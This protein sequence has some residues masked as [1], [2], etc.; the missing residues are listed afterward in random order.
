MPPEH[1]RVAERQHRDR[2]GDGG[3]RGGRD[4]RRRVARVDC[5]GSASGSTWSRRRRCRIA[6]GRNRRRPVAA[7]RVGEHVTRELAPSSSEIW[8]S[9]CW[10]SAVARLVTPKMASAVPTNA[11]AS[12]ALR[13]PGSRS[14]GSAST[15]SEG[16]LADRGLDVAVR[17][18]G[19]DERERD[20]DH[21]LVELHL[22]A[23][24][25]ADQLVDRPV[26]QV[27]PY[28]RAPIHTSAGMPSIRRRDR[29]ADASSPR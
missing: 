9:F 5:V 4:G 19:D 1:H 24:D 7:R 15:T 3:R 6:A 22:L 13:R 29:A 11:P 16:A 25:V 17:E 20:R 23:G 8:T 21:E 12:T 18:L 14:A 28:E 10:S 2:H 26:V 27:Q